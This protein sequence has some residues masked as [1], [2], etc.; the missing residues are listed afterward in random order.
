MNDKKTTIKDIAK[1]ANVAVSTVSRVL[2]NLDRVNPETRKRVQQTI[3][4]LGYIQNP[5]AASIITGQS[6]IILI[7]VPDFSNLFFGSV[8]RGAEHCLHEHGYLSIVITSLIEDKEQISF[9]LQHIS[10]LVDG[11]IIIPNVTAKED[12]CRFRKPIVCV[13]AAIESKRY[14][15]V[16]VD[17]RGGMYKLA[18]HLIKSGHTKIGVLLGDPRLSIWNDSNAGFRQAM[19]DYN[20]PV[21]EQ[22]V[23]SKDFHEEAGMEMTNQLLD[24]PNPPTALITGNSLLTNGCIYAL[25]RRSLAIGKDISL[26]GFDDNSATSKGK[27]GITAIKRAN[28]DMGKLAAQLLLNRFSHPDAKPQTILLPVE[29]VERESVV[30]LQ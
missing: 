20:I 7:V 2:N 14:D 13:D 18:E 27:P 15:H 30:K 8:I 26:V 12:F 3:E 5:F 10:Y 9:Y 24:L 28:E 6:K 11:A 23:I 19:R 21:D 22:Y 29:L 16:F 4:K 17:N 1:E 25:Q